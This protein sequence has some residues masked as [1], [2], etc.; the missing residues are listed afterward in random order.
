M[1]EFSG[2]VA[3]ITGGASG[4]GLAMAKR[5]AA[6]GM[7]IVLG[8][9]EEPALDKAVTELRRGGVDVL[10]VPTDVADH[11]AV[12]SLKDRTL[13]HFGAVHLV[14]NNA[15]VVGRSIIE[16]PMEVWEWVL[17]VN[18]MGVVHG[19]NVFLP[20][21][22]EQGEG[23]IVNTGSIAGL[24]GNAILGIYCTTKF[25]VVG[26]S[27]S[28]H[29]E[30]V[31]AGSN[32]KVSVLCPGFVQTRIAHSERNAPAHLRVEQPDGDV[33]SGAVMTIGIPPAEVAEAVFDAVSQERL[34]VLTHL[35]MA[36]SSLDQRLELLF[37][38]TS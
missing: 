30:L 13:E 10:G 11:S 29:E 8:D 18:L 38:Q 7:R 31:A 15:G 27:E 3:V 16:S 2:K 19:C 6:E 37:G 36:K 32:V 35:D 12:V 22:V 26:L 21:L 34:Y 5:F 4:I 28:L 24:R 23:H 14:C 25:A 20:V 1:K 17:G 33:L 9:I